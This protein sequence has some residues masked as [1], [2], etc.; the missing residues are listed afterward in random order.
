MLHRVYAYV[1]FGQ[2]L[3]HFL[4]II[5]HTNMVNAWAKYMYMIINYIILLYPNVNVVDVVGGMP[6]LPFSLPKYM[7]IVPVCLAS[8]VVLASQ[9]LNLFNA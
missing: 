4:F 8:A 1:T 5:S 2:G 9:S 7:H 3:K 6:F